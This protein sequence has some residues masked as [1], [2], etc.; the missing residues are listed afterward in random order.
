LPLLDAGQVVES[1]E[2]VCLLSLLRLGFGG[3]TMAGLRF[4]V[5]R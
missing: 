5:G 2:F 4:R 1:T 3:W